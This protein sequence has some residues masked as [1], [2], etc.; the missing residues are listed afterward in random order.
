MYDVYEGL[1]DVAVMGW[2]VQPVNTGYSG[3]AP[4]G[5]LVAASQARHGRSPDQL[6]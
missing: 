6:L 4:P 5:S 2:A 3:L 1:Q